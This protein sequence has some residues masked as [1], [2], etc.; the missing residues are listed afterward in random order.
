MSQFQPLFN[1]VQSLVGPNKLPSAVIGVA[2]R[3]GMLDQTA[4][5]AAVRVGILDG[6]DEIGAFQVGRFTQEAAP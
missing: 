3:N 5:P 4:H 6:P 2:D 1:F